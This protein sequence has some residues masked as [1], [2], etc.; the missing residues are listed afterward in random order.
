MAQN[1]LNGPINIVCFGMTNMWTAYFYSIELI[2]RHRIPSLTRVMWWN[3]IGLTAAHHSCVHFILASR[4]GTCHANRFTPSMCSIIIKIGGGFEFRWSDKI[5][6]ITG[7]GGRDDFFL[8]QKL[9]NPVHIHHI[10]FNHGL[11][12]FS[13]YHFLKNF[14]VYEFLNDFV[15]FTSL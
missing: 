2:K 14:T 13:G 10:A 7:N 12:I 6:G 1:F 15:C 3:N 11:A 9:M 4:N 8:H 5:F